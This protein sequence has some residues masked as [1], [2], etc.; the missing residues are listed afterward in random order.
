MF[1]LMVRFKRHIFSTMAQERRLSAFF[2]PR[3][4]RFRTGRAFDRVLIGT[5]TI[6]TPPR[7]T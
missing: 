4:K 1:D 6:A 2:L 5:Q 3:V 7:A